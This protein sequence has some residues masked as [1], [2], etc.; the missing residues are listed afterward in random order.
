M[1]KIILQILPVIGIFVF[2]QPAVYAQTSS[3]IL[4][5]DSA[6]ERLIEKN[7]SVEAARLEVSAAEQ[8]KVYARLRPRPTLNVSTE[9]LRIA[10]STPF[11]RLYEIGAVVTQPIEL[12]G[13][14]NAR[15]EVAERTITLAEARLGGILRQRLFEMRRVFY[16]ALLAQTRLVLEEENSTNFGELLRYSEVRL[17]EGDISPGEVIKLRLERIKYDSALAN[18]RLDLRQSRIKL[19]ELI[20]ETDFSRI[21]QMELRETFDFQDF[22]LNLAALKQ[23]ALDDRPEIKV[24]EAELARAESV[25]KLER[26]R[27]KGEIEPYAGYRRVGVDNTVLVGVNIP[28]PF[29][30]R[31]QTGI[32]QAEA[33]RK[34]AETTLRQIQNRTLAEIET[35]Y[36]AFETAREQVKA[37]EMGVLKQAD[38][39][40]DISLLA[41]REGAIDLINLLEAQRTRTEVRNN[42]Y[43]TLLSYY[44][45]LFQLERLTGT[46]IKK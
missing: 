5:L 2:C 41:Y 45:S 28:L 3:D 34:I 39:S 9:N 22:S 30:S 43:L 44:T 46:E 8:Q 37:F 31:N 7:L 35:A 21:E 12:G 6:S 17:Q 15:T 27:S 42:Y 38:E 36:L 33:D 24:A 1:K 32:A 40:R 11:T 29:G 20:G 25:F 4:T 10:G 14:K 16:E 23:A 13:R 19:L 26:S 18:S